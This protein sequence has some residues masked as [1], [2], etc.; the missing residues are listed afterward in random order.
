MPKRA[1]VALADDYFAKHRDELVCAALE[2]YKRKS[3]DP[4]GLSLCKCHREIGEKMKVSSSGQTLDAQQAA[5]AA[6]GAGGLTGF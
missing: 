4:Q 3:P 5:P 2:R 6:A 1:I